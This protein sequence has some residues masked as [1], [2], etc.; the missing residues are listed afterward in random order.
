[1][2]T[3]FIEEFQCPG[4]ICGSDTK[5]GRFRLEEE[6]GFFR[7][8]GHV[9]GTYIQGVRSGLVAL[10]LPKGFNRVGPSEEGQTTKIRI[11][12]KDGKPK[13][14]RANVPVWTMEQ[15][16]FLF[17]RVFSPRIDVTF[18]DIVEG[19]KR[20]ELAPSS[21]DVGTFIDEID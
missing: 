16:G 3:K 4:C 18:V 1:M 5:C 12:P 2:K 7:C 9:P 19:G 13:W 10:G 20:E 11:F 15:D 8:G 21:I 14:D 17:A 6:E